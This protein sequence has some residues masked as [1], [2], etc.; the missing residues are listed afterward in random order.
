[1]HF[2]Y[3]LESIPTGRWY[4]GSTENVEKRLV[5]HNRGA[6]SSTKP[7]RP[8]RIVYTETYPTKTN[9]LQR[10]RQIKRSGGI[11]QAI[12]AQINTAPSS[13]G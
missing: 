12:K 13:N 9:A 7:Y 6:T 3:I 8:Y 4:V 10:E 2:V 5:E 1:M 11:R